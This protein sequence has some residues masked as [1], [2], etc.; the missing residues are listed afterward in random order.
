V[1]GSLDLPGCLTGVTGLILI[2]FAFNQGPVV[3]WP[4]VYVYV[5][6]IVGFLFMGAFGES[7]ECLIGSGRRE[8]S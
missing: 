8:K 2:N 3:G 4:T 6:L 7:Y 1:K 5:L